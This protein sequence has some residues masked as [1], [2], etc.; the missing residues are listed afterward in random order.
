MLCSGVE[1]EMPHWPIA[2]QIAYL[3][4]PVAI[5]LAINCTRLKISIPMETGI[6]IIMCMARM[7]REKPS[8][9]VSVASPPHQIAAFHSL[10][11]L[12]LSSTPVRMLESQRQCFTMRSAVYKTM[13][14]ARYRSGAVLR[15][16]AAHGFWC[17]LF[18]VSLFDFCCL[19]LFLSAAGVM[20]VVAGFY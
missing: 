8:C 18:G 17:L 19:S 5:S 14:E 3:S 1:L 4:N 15:G 20:W 11:P 9:C 10:T 6:H 16:G 7:N 2:L 13:K 12:T